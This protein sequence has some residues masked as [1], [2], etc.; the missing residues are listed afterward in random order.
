M[1]D[2][3]Y[4]EKTLK[5]INKPQ[6]LEIAAANGIEVPDGATNDVIK[7]LIIAKG[8]PLPTNSGTNS[9]LDTENKSGEVVEDE[10]VPKFSKEQLVNSN[11]YSHRRD[12]LAVLLDDDKMY[13]H[14]AVDRMIGEF[15]KGKVK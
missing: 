13:S 14:A 8:C 6:L 11:W 1:E 5:N 4:T 15:M 10:S 12:V 9:P 3:M 2:T 7:G